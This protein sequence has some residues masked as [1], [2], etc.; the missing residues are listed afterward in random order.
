MSFLEF[1][2]PPL[3]IIAHLVIAPYTKVEE[4]FNLQAT[5]DILKYGIPTNGGVIKDLFDHWTFPGAVPRSFVGAV[6]LAGCG[7]GFRGLVGEQVV[8]RAV[9]GLFTAASITHF[10]RAVRKTFGATTARWFL[11]MLLS[12]FHLPFY[13]SRPL[14]NTFAMVFVNLGMAGFLR[15]ISGERK[16]R[17]L[18]I[19]FLTFTGIVF[20]SEVALLLATQILWLLYTR[21]THLF[22]EVL[23]AGLAGAVVGLTL[24]LSVDSHLWQSWDP[25]TPFTTPFLTEKLGLLWPEFSAFWFNTV[26]NHASDWGTSP[27][28]YYF[29]NA[30]PRLL[31]NPL[32]LLSIPIAVVIDQRSRD[33]VVPLL[34]YVAVYSILPHKE[35]RFVIYV[36]PGLTT[37]AAVGASWIWNRR[38]KSIFYALASFSLVVSVLLSFVLAGTMAVISAENYPGGVAME[39]LHSHLHTHFLDPTAGKITV[40]L[41]VPVCMTGASRFLQDAPVFSPLLPEYSERVAWD[42]TE[43][44]EKLAKDA[45]WRGIDWAVISER[46]QRQGEWEVVD[47]VKGFKRVR[48]YRP[49]EEVEA[50]DGTW[51]RGFKDGWGLRKLARGWWVGVEK[52]EKAWVVKRVK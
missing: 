14:P 22:R 7:K 20:R 15:S 9:L 18:G 1:L 44:E 32:T 11:F 43:D 29:L 16:G 40:H 48:V 46:S 41:D 10:S 36:I 28:W 50:G 34:A 13:A 27:W 23:P 17:M 5:H 35:W 42:K 45:F 51:N 26:G 33:V 2:L 52:E 6:M 30:I 37:A 47:V 38:S 12:Q 3:V 49:G 19:Y 25:S 39:N 24:T 21:R 8:V 4:S 31:L